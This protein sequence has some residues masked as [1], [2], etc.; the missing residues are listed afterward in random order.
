[1]AK[2]SMFTRTTTSTKCKVLI[3]NLAE[4]KPEEIE[5][6]VP[7]KFKDNKK[8]T[9]ALRAKIDNGERAFVNVK[10]AEIV[11]TLRGM[12]EEEFFE[13]SV[14]LPPRKVKAEN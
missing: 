3:M 6:E 10:K 5:V 8:L 13:H 1:M 7:G 9:A 11:N 12:T 2:A 14:V 4:E